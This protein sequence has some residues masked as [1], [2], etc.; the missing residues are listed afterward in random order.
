[1][2]DEDI[3]KVNEVSMTVVNRNRNTTVDTKKTVNQDTDNINKSNADTSTNKTK[4]NSCERD[5]QKWSMLNVRPIDVNKDDL[6]KDSET[7]HDYKLDTKERPD[8][9]DTNATLMDC[10]INVQPANGKLNQGYEEI[11][12]VTETQFDNNIIITEL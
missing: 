6:A 7:E 4:E 9:K 3:E 11:N 12:G 5:K 1:M 10:L 8:Y 2:T